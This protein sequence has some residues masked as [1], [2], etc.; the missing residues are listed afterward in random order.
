MVNTQQWLNQAYPKEERK[1]IDVL[2]IADNNLEGLLDL[3]D[4]TNLVILNCSNNQ[5]TDVL[6]PES[7]SLIDIILFPNPFTNPKQKLIESWNIHRDIP[8]KYSSSNDKFRH[9]LPNAMKLIDI[10]D[11]D[12]WIENYD[13][14]RQGDKEYHKI[15]GQK[16]HGWKHL[17]EDYEDCPDSALTVDEAGRATL[18]KMA[19]QVL[20]RCYIQMNR[21]LHGEESEWEERMIKIATNFT[22]K[23]HQKEFEEHIDEPELARLKRLLEEKVRERNELRAEVVAVKEK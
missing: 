9:L 3:R 20:A 2:H 18:S 7:N 17:D 19:Q 4:F 21:L 1:N 10:S 16:F 23:T 13:F 14:S 22:G 8:R 15:M 11:L 12:N 6:L 5:L